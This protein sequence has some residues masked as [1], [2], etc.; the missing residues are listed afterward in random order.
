MARLSIVVL[1]ALLGATI[2][3]PAAAQWKWRDKGGQIQYSDLPPPAG[4]SEQDILQRP[5][6]AQRRTPTP[7]VAAASAAPAA[8]AASRRV[9]PELEAKRRKVEEELAAKNK[10]DQEKAAAQRAE[11]C[12]RARGYARTLDD[13]VRIVRTNEKGE[14]E[15]LDDKAR[16]EETKKARE[17]IAADCK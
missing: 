16:A 17:I 2:A 5:S 10:A 15:I 6:A 3:M 7:S 12:A 1:S 13:G 11:S 9:E 8:D 4:V 14:R